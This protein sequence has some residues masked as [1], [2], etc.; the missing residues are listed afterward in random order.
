MNDKSGF[1]KRLTNVITDIL[2]GGAVMQALA[3]LLRAKTAAGVAQ[4]AVIPSEDRES[5]LL[6]PPSFPAPFQLHPGWSIPR[7]STLPEPTYTPAV[8][9]LGIVF[10]ALGVVTSYYVSAVGLL[11]F[12]IS[13]IIWIGELL[14]ER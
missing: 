8:F 1:G 4:P 11:L 13:L 10:L 6:P 12:L 5:Q 3:D 9:A 2:L 14:N 7:P